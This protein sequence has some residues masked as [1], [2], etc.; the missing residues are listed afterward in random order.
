MRALALVLCLAAGAAAAS[1]P[2]VSPRPLARPFAAEVAERVAR[3]VAT[4]RN[5]GVDVQ[6]NLVLLSPRPLDR[7]ENLRRRSTVRAAG[8]QIL[9]PGPVAGSICGV[10]G[11]KGER[12]RPIAGRISA[13]GVERPVRVTS[14]DGLTLSQAAI[15]DCPTAIALYTW[16]QRGLKPAI[17]RLGGGPRGLK[18]AA[19]YVCRTRNGQTGAKV[20]EH[21]KGRAVDISA[22]T[23]AN[24]QELTVLRGWQHP[25][26]GRRFRAMHSAACGTFGTVL[27]PNSDRFHRDHF[28]FDTARYRSGA[29]CR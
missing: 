25:Q 29:Y 18:V 12:L 3:T 27:G 11:I 4:S 14:V 22:V 1:P 6:R 28:H 15:M 2:E 9:P 26:H 13:C 24:G 21:G 7:P 19:H 20:S 16:A 5:A 17:G 23:L 10:R 8:L